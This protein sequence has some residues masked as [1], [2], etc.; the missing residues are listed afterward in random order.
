MTVE[1]C[2]ANK[3]NNQDRNFLGKIRNSKEVICYS[4]IKKSHYFKSCPDQPKKLVLILAIFV[5]MTEASRKDE[6]VLKK[7]LCIHYP[8]RFCK[9][10]AEV[11]A[12]LDSNS[13]VN[14]IKLV[15]I[16]K[17]GLNIC[18]TNIEARKINSSTLDTF[19]KVLASLW[20]E[21]KLDHAQY[22]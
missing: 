13:K 17:I 9:N 21:D 6:V 5:S 22:F 14:T 4:C 7:V 20:V 10:I 19:R 18:F 1:P 2:R 3:M 8:L 12:F 15:Y 16:A 11:K